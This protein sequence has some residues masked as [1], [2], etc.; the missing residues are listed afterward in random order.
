MV[1]TP[2][3]PISRTDLSACLA[4]QISENMAKLHKCHECGV[5]HQKRLWSTG[6]NR[7]SSEPRKLCMKRFNPAQYSFQRQ[8]SAIQGAFG[9]SEFT[10][11]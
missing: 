9:R 7:R 1:K 3:S 10:T 2:D 5:V 4:I 8:P 6:D 11:F